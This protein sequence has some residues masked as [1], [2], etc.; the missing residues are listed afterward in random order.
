[1]DGFHGCARMSEAQWFL[2]DVA[3]KLVVKKSEPIVGGRY[4]HLKRTRIRLET[5]TFISADPTHLVGV[6]QAVEVKNLNVLTPYVEGE[7]PKDSP[8]LDRE[9]YRIYRTCVGT[10]IYVS[11]DRVDLQGEIGLLASILAAP[12]GRDWKRLVRVARFGGKTTTDGVRGFPN[13]FM[14][15]K[16][17]SG[18]STMSILTMLPISIQGGV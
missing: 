9:R 2:E 18:W 10:L 5:G 11:C 3:D 6:A 17:S 8:L 13:Q 12:T 1:M 15:W 16:G 7:R 4:A 14:Q